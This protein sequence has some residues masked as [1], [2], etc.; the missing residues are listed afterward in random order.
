MAKLSVNLNKIATLRNTRPQNVPDLLHFARLALDAG[1]A[2]LT[3]HPRPDERHIRA[4]DVAPLATLCRERDVE[5][6]IEGNPFEGRFIEHCL[7][8]RPTQ[9][10]LVPDTPGQSTSDHGWP[11]PASVEPLQPIV[12]QLKQAGIRV[13]LFV[14]HDADMAAAAATGADRVEL[15]T[16][17][18]AAAP[19]IARPALL[20]AFADAAQRAAAV[21]LGVNAGHD[22]DFHNLPPLIRA[23][24]ALAE[25]SIGHALIADALENGFDATVRHYIKAAASEKARSS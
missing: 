13:S 23:I 7:A 22:L 21:N 20:N 18:Y 4:A 25:V 6:N 16:E 17:P 1:A 24:P 15:Y 3:V 10:T 19:E 2:G 12:A 14:D 11:L 9:A 5:F 8:N